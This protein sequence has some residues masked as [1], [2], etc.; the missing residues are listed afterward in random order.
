M[1]KYVVTC[2]GTNSGTVGVFEFNTP[3][4][5]KR[6]YKDAEAVIRMHKDSKRGSGGPSTAAGLMYT[7]SEK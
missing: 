4:E 3:E 1:S 2:G 5:K 7:I 6:A